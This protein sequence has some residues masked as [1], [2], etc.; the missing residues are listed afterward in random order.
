MQWACCYF[1]G[2]DALLSFIDDSVCR[3]FTLC[4]RIL[5]FLFHSSFKCCA[6][7]L[8]VFSVSVWTSCWWRPRCL[9][10]FIRHFLINEVCLPS[11][12][13]PLTPTIPPP[14]AFPHSSLPSSCVLESIYFDLCPP[15]FLLN[16]YFHNPFFFI[17]FLHLPASFLLLRYFW[18]SF[19]R[20]PFCQYYSLAL[21]LLFLTTL[22]CLLL[23]N[24]PDRFWG[25]FFGNC[26]LW[27]TLISFSWHC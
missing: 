19:Q 24:S 11:S 17:I 12:S 2:V 26:E 15:P 23:S 18:P 6:V 21:L 20:Y 16:L 9:P 27:S 1:S 13:S 10:L 22:A 4:G 14:A 8:F 25:V 3:C 5:L 7:S